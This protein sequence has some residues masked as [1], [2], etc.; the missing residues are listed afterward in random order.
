MPDAPILSNDDEF[1]SIPSERT[2]RWGAPGAIG[3]IDHY[4]LVRKLGGGGFGVVYLAKDTASGIDVA[5]K[6]LHP[7]LKNNTEEMEGLRDKFAL[8][9][10]LAHPN[11]A[12]ALVLHP[13]RDIQVWGEPAR[14]E[15]G[16]QSGDSVMVMRYAPGT[17]L[18]KWRRQFPGGVVPFELA[19]EVG[20]QVAA[21]LDYAHGE[22][23]VHRDIKPEN[24]MVE[25]LGAGLGGREGPAG[26][27]AQDPKIR[28]RILDFGLAAEIRSS[29]GRLSR[30]QGD[31]S[32]TRPYMAPEQW[33]GKAQDGR[34]DQYALACVLYELLS[35]EP[36]FAG[37]FETGDPDIM[38]TAVATQAPEGL[39]FLGRAVDAALA[40]ALAKDPAN[41][42]PSCAAFLAAMDGS[43]P[44]ESAPAAEPVRRR[45][46]RAPGG[47]RIPVYVYTAE[48]G[49]AWQ[50]CDPR[51]AESLQK[52]LASTGVLSRSDVWG[53]IIRR[54]VASPAWPEWPR[55]RLC[56]I[57]YR[58]HRS[59]ARDQMGRGSN[60]I[61][62][63]CLPVSADRRL[64]DFRA[65][66]DAPPMR[67]ALRGGYEDLSIDLGAGDGFLLTGDEEPEASLQVVSWEESWKEPAF[68]SGPDVLLLLS[69]LFQSPDAD[70]GDLKAVVRQVDG[71][72][73][74]TAAI[75]AYTVFP[76]VSAARAAQAAFEA[77]PAVPPGDLAAERN[78]LGAWKAALD[79]VEGLERA[80]AGFR[81]LA[82]FAEG[83]RQSFRNARMRVSA[84][85]RAAAEM[86]REREAALA[87]IAAL[88]R[89]LGAFSMSINETR[90]Q[91]DDDETLAAI[92]RLRPESEGRAVLAGVSDPGLRREVRGLLQS[93]QER[94]DGLKRKADKIRALWSR[95]RS[96][97]M[98]VEKGGGVS[99]DLTALVAGDLSSA[100][101]LAGGLPFAA[102]ILE[103]MRNRFRMAREMLRPARPSRPARPA[104]PPTRPAVPF[105]AKRAPSFE[106]ILPPERRSR[107]NRV[108]DIAPFVMGAVLVALLIL[109]VWQALT[110][111]DTD[112]A[113]GGNPDTNGVDSASVDTNETG[114]AS[115]PAGA[116]EGAATD[117][118]AVDAGPD[119]KAVDAGKGEKAVDAGKDGKAEDAGKG[120]KA[121]DAGKDDKA[122]NPKKGETAVDAG[123]DEKAER[124][125]G[126]R[127]DERN[128]K[129]ESKRG[130]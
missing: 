33:L 53:G 103:D 86:S 41:R 95:V 50:G 28:V 108:V 40:R 54:P 4:D 5:I 17:T 7:L 111:P 46:S 56:T 30:D 68:V 113:F 127:T 60:Y 43:S 130:R 71:E 35:G 120:E 82:G 37:V 87:E 6:T 80:C 13:C 88:D 8:V 25:T 22:K 69:G 109:G 61:A 105:S 79:A 119:D 74:P 12:T 29:M 14:G 98:A 67:R 104:P 128:A 64:V 73:V 125:D 62:A 114:H 97:Q 75:L 42:F 78:A 38:K 93:W 101:A 117:G 91:D 126:G 65:V 36:P 94:F 20:R 112:P 66:F 24:I 31:T 44:A 59:S 57:L 34:T 106:D 26:R 92:A 32:G 11:I 129:A 124:P 81:G 84:D 63:A 70:L 83:Q 48:N 72:S 85:E 110:P 10:R 51:T 115:A 52:A 116:P 121:M 89:A 55:S 90:G 9:S 1:G 102:D 2:I 19:L 76:Q 45:P 18:S 123:K 96:Y 118:A 15:L 3:R 99:A 100:E 107:W 47:G 27:P 77:L 16:L 122:G 23:I 21:A 49:Y 39:G 58:F